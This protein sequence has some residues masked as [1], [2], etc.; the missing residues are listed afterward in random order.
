MTNRSRATEIAERLREGFYAPGPLRPSRAGRISP[1]RSAVY[2]RVKMAIK[3]KASPMKWLRRRH[4]HAY[5][6]SVRTPA[7]MR[8]VAAAQ[9]L[10]RAAARCRSRETVAR[11]SSAA[12]PG[13]ICESKGPTWRKET[14]LCSLR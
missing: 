14:A 5:C 8:E 10:L 3:H 12:P 13:F 6:G 11:R 4:K 2:Q 9:A 7:R 1:E